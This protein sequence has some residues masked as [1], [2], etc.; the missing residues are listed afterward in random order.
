MEHKIFFLDYFCIFHRL[1]F[2]LSALPVPCSNTCRCHY[3]WEHEANVFNCSNTNITS[4]TQLQIPYKTT[5][6]I[7]KFN[8]IPHLDWSVHLSHIEHFDLQNS[9]VRYIA[10][11]FFSKIKTMNTTKFLNLAN[12]DLKAFP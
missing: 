5:W 3:I 4:L 11:D 12:N 2:L 6:L 7:A 10:E 1:D 9:S 8:N